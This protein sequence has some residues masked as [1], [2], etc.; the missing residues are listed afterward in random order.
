[1]T[2]T[3]PYSAAAFDSQA[4][5]TPKDQTVRDN[6]VPALARRIRAAKSTWVVHLRSCGKG[7]KVTLG[8]CDAIPVA[9]A[10]Q[11]ALE[12]LATPSSETEAAPTAGQEAPRLKD[13][14]QTFLADC[15]GRWKESTF[16]TNVRAVDRL[17]VPAFGTRRLDRIE[18][19]DV[20]QWLEDPA[21]ATGSKYRALPVLS[22]LFDHA[23]LLGKLCAPARMGNSASGDDS[24]VGSRFASG[25][26]WCLRS[27]RQ[28]R[29]FLPVD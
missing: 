14:A 4:Q 27:V 1:M 19:E 24:V 13:F 28:G 18:P 26:L 22:A 29:Y 7:S 2:K 21:I 5:P 15:R 8:D 17:L 23:A 20:V 12:L 16:D 6:V 11:M 10:R 9:R 25:G 3:T